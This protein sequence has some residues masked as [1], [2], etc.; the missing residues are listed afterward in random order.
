MEIW[1]INL[2]GEIQITP[3]RISNEMTNLKKTQNER[4]GGIPKPHRWILRVE[5]LN[6]FTSGNILKL[7]SKTE[8]VMDMMEGP[9]TK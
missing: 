6:G 3:R 7:L 8:F 1:V 2:F 9:Q 4:A 5:K